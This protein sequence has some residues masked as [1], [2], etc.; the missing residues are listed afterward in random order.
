MGI[1]GFL[2]HKKEDDSSFQ[3]TS[4][5]LGLSE[6]NNNSNSDSLGFKPRF[7]EDDKFEMSS[8]PQGMN[9]KDVQLLLTKMEVINQK[10]ELI[11]RRLQEIERLAKE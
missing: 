8:K 3:D 10:L 6:D 1:F 2:K 4:A 11:D 7:N 5:D 9:D